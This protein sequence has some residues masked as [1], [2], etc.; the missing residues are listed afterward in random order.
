[1]NTG[2]RY[3]AARTQCYTRSIK[4]SEKKRKQKNR[5][6][7]TGQVSTITDE[8]RKR[9][10]KGGRGEGR[11]VYLEIETEQCR[12]THHSFEKIIFPYAV[13][14]VSS[15]CRSGSCLSDAPCNPRCFLSISSPLH[16]HRPKSLPPPS[17]SD[18]N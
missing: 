17:N 18:H 16:F 9:E 7:Y 6:K 5:R 12:V 1:M 2:E 4:S 15:D 11:K 8:E 10:R 14:F 3:T 13:P